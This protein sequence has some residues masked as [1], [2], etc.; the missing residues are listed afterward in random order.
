MPRRHGP[1]DYLRLDTDAQ[2]GKG[3]VIPATFTSLKSRW[4]DGVP[5]PAITWRNGLGGLRGNPRRASTSPSAP[6]ATT[7]AHGSRRGFKYVSRRGFIFA[8]NPAAGQ[9]TIAQGCAA[10]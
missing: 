2:Q 1:G 7:T 4:G 9:G 8:S 3:Y 10:P 5:R 6:S